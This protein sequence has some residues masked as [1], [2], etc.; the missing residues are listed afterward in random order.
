MRAAIR[1]D[2]NE[3]ATLTSRANLVAVINGTTV[4][5]LGNIISL[6]KRHHPLT[7]YALVCALHKTCSRG[8]QSSDH[9][10]TTTYGSNQTGLMR[11]SYCRN[12]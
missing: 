2:P 5:G 8:I 7:Q 11:A 9:A 4:L 10:V 6:L 12:S 1:D 3:A